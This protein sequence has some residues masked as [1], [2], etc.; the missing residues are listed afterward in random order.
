M[1][2]SLPIPTVP[3]VCSCTSFAALYS[4]PHICCRIEKVEEENVNEWQAME[5][6]A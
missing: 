5:F 6:T 4:I 3:N 1:R 2:D